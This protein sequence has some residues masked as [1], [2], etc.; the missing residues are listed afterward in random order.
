M[1][2][3][4]K[5][6]LNKDKKNKSGKDEGKEQKKMKEFSAYSSHKEYPIDVHRD[7]VWKYSLL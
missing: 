1:V 4:A 3:K 5:K 2:V 6:E 7:T